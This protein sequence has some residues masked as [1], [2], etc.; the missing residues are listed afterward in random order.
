MRRWL[1]FRSLCFLCVA[2]AFAQ[3]ETGSV[4]RNGFHPFVEPQLSISEGYT[5]G[6]SVDV[7]IEWQRPQFLVHAVAGYGFLR[8]DNDND[9]VP[10]ERGHTRSLGAD[11]FLREGQTFVGPGFTWG[12]TAVT[13]YRKYAWAPSIGGGHDFRYFRLT[14][15][16]FRDRRE[17]TDYPNAIVFTP[18]PGQPSPSPYC[19]CSNGVTGVG[20]EAWYSP[21]ESARVVFDYSCSVYR[22]HT[23]VTDPY[24]TILTASQQAERYTGAGCGF[25]LVIRR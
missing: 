17:Y 8:K 3:T 4:W 23:T 24:N 9:Q 5:I 6:P 2:R 7:G 13:P 20:V 16:Y 18:G 14:A 19:I 25:G 12:E 21:S 11:L 22:F 15:D 10:N 1:L